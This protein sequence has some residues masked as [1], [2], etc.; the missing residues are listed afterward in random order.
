MKTLEAKS[1]RKRDLTDARN[2]S[3]HAGYDEGARDTRRK[4]MAAF[5]EYLHNHDT[6]NHNTRDLELK[7]LKYVKE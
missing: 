4:L 2:R 3:Y 7:L 1:I 6:G 5:K